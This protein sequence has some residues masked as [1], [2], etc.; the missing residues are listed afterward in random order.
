MLPMITSS[1]SVRYVIKSFYEAGEK[2]A[3]GV[4]T[5]CTQDSHPQNPTIPV[6]FGP[7]RCQGV[8]KTFF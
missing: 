8:G 7:K 1:T 4:L 6:I 5:Q 2:I 3:R